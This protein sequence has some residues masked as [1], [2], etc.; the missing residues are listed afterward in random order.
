MFKRARQQASTTTNLND[1]KGWASAR[2]KFSRTSNAGLG[3]RSSGIMQKCK[4]MPSCFSL[5][6]T[7][8]AVHLPRCT[9]LRVSRRVRRRIK[10]EVFRIPLVTHLVDIDKT[11]LAE[12]I[13]RAIGSCGARP[14]EP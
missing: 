14:V 8:F 13:S 12:D 6:T 1:S 4:K 2:Q 3:V 9:W 7:Q 11:Q 10:D 5:V